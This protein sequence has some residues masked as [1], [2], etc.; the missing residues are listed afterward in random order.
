[1]SLAARVLGKKPAN[2][3]DLEPKVLSTGVGG[4]QAHAL[5][6]NL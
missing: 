4:V 3:S 2:T 5:D 6:L 1:M